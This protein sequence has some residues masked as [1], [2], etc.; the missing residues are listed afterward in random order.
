M[1]IL[2]S[3]RTCGDTIGIDEPSVLSLKYFDLIDR[4]SGMPCLG[5]GKHPAPKRTTAMKRFGLIRDVTLSYPETDTHSSWAEYKGPRSKLLLWFA[6]LF[7]GQKWSGV[8]VN[9]E[10]AW[11]SF[12]VG[13]FGDGV[14]ELEKMRTEKT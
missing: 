12:D 13:F 8:V 2:L 4:I 1:S 5:H 11:W 7:N 14:K 10:W 9:G 6:I 3:C